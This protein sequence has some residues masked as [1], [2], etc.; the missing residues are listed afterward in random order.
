MAVNNI[1][2][3]LISGIQNALKSFV[4]G[5]V[6]GGGSSGGDSKNVFDPATL[7][8][9]F[10]KSAEIE[11]GFDKPEQKAEKAIAGLIKD[12][13]L[14]CAKTA[15]LAPPPITAAFMILEVSKKIPELM[16]GRNMSELSS[17]YL[18][19][20]P[21][22]LAGK[23]DSVLGAFNK[24]GDKNLMSFAN[25]IGSEMQRYLG[26][27]LPLTPAQTNGIDMTAEIDQSLD[28]SHGPKQDVSQA[29]ERNM[30]QSGPSI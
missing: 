6:G 11:S 23:V 1:L 29:R 4:N 14:E 26:K 17:D 24:T 21:E 19:K 12:T 30:S 2:S 5:L 7:M 13:M 25:Q 28:Q 16:S 8:D 18:L 27:A 10:N 20:N 9:F 3:S 15:A 22:V